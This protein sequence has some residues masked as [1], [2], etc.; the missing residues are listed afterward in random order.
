MSSPPFRPRAAPFPVLIA[1][2]G[3]SNSRYALVGPDGRPDRMQVMGN[4]DCPDLQKRHRPL[5]R[6]DRRPPGDGGA[7]AWRGR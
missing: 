2:I 6:Q 3:G 7:R 4:D 1:D 5:S